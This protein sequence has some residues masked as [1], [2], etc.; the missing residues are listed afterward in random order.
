MASPV[1]IGRHRA[2]RNA[3]MVLYKLDLVGPE[4]NAAGADS[5]E[6]AI[7]A[8][9]TEHGFELP[10]YAGAL[11]RGVCADIGHIDRVLDAYLT[12]WRLERLGAVERAILR[13]G[14]LELLS[15]DVPAEVAI[16]EAVEL[17][18]RYASPEAA[19][20][21]NGVL[22]AWLREHG[23]NSGKEQGDG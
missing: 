14:M 20:L 10:P 6:Q 15:R 7:S 5:V 1:N 12:D 9:A 16:D 4:E 23:E 13:I 17:A 18:K 8:F 22:G 3:M 11:V 2:R 19:K 21:V